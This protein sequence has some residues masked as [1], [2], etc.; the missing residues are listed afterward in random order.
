MI[1][2]PGEPQKSVLGK[3]WS[4][5]ISSLKAVF[6]PWVY[7]AD[8]SIENQRALEISRQ[9]HNKEL[10]AQRQVFRK[11]ELELSEWQRRNNLSFQAIQNE[12]HRDLQRETARLQHD[13]T[14]TEGRFNRQVQKEL[15]EA[16]RL[17]TTVEGDKNRQLQEYLAQLQRELTANEGQLNRE[18][19]L[20]LEMIRV[21]MQRWIIEQQKALQLKI[22]EIDV[23]LAWELRE[24][25]RRT[26]LNN[27]RE[28]RRLNNLPICLL[29]EDILGKES[30]SPLPLRVFISPPSIRY[31]R[32]GS[33]NR[34]GESELSRYFPLMEQA[35]ERE[36][37][38][39]CNHYV[40]H[41]RPLNPMGGAWTSKAFHGETA[42]LAMFNELH[43]EPVL[44]LE[45]AP[46]GS[47]FDLNCAFWG[48]NWK[49]PLYHTALSVD[50]HESL[51]ELAKIRTLQWQEK[52]VGKTQTQLEEQFGKEVV[53]RYQ[54]NLKMIEREQRCVAD[55]MDLKDIDRPYHIA[56]KDSERFAHFL[57]TCHCLYTG[58][59]A[60]EYFLVHVPPTVRQPPLL[61]TLLPE[62]L[63]EVPK[64]LIPDLVSIMVTFY[65]FLYEKLGEEL[66][67]WKPQLYLELA[68]S[69]IVLSDQS[70]TKVQVERAI[71]IWMQ[72][73]GIQITSNEVPEEKSLALENVPNYATM[74]SIVNAGDK[75]FFDRLENCL[76]VL[77]A[78][79]ETLPTVE[80]FL[81]SW[82]RLQKERK[83]TSPVFKRL[84]VTIP[85]LPPQ[86]GKTMSTT[87]TTIFN[88]KFLQIQD[89]YQQWS[90]LQEK[91][92][93]LLGNSASEETGSIVET[94]LKLQMAIKEFKHEIDNPRITLATTGTT[95]GGKSS[96]VN[97]LCGAEII[98]VAV[99]EMSAGT[100]VIDHHSTKRSLKI[101]PVAGLPADYSGEWSDLSDKDIRH[102]LQK[103]MD[104]YRQ[105]R[106]EN[107]EPSAPRMEIQY[108]TRLGLHPELAG[109]PEG[110]KL[111]IIDLPGLKYVADEHNRQVIREEIKPALC[112]VTYNSEETDPN[113]QQ[114]L[115]E[116]VVEQV[117]EL[118]GSPA[119]MLFVLNRI[120]VFRRDENWQEQTKN[121][122]NKVRQKIRTAVAQSLPEYQKQANEINAQ[123]LST[124]PALCAYQVLT[125]DSEELCVQ[126]LEKIDSH[127][128]AL[129][130]EELVDELPRKISKWR[131]T[132]RKQVAEA[133]WRSSYGH[134]FDETLR[135]HIQSHIPQ[136]LLPHLVKAV[137]D[138]DG[139]ALT[140]A[141]QIAHAH[142]NATKERYQAECN[143]LN[144]I[145]ADLQQLRDNSKQ[146]LLAILD[147]SEDE[148]VDLIEQLTDVA[149]QLQ[150]TYQLPKDSLVPLYDWTIQLGNTI[151]SFLSAI[152]KAIREKSTEPQSPLTDS[153]PP[154]ERQAL[155]NMLVH[156]NE[157]GYI[158]YAEEGGHFDTDN[159]SQKEELKKMNQALN[160]LAEVIAKSLRRLLE[161]TAEREAG[162]IQ[163]ALQ[164]LIEQY[165]LFISEQA[166]S[167]APDLAALTITP[168]KLSRIKQRLILNFNLTAGFPIHKK[169]KEIQVG[170]KEVWVGTERVKTG[171]EEVKVGEKR[172]W[173]T[174]WIAKKAIYET[175]DKYETRDKYKREA[176]YEKRNYE[177]ATIPSIIDVFG[178]FIGQAKASR[179]EAEFV[180]WLHEQVDEFLTGIEE[181]QEDLLKEYRRRLDQAMQQA[182]QQKEMD[183]GKWQPVAEQVVVLQN[184]L[185]KLLKVE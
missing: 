65:E 101:P 46:E 126:S 23:K 18:Q 51:Y 47:K 152:D 94:D 44:I 67:A 99:Q 142:L 121:F 56:S 166:Y 21:E 93:Q 41:N 128:R 81:Q 149:S 167:L 64:E 79:G 96:L 176:V 130:P 31:D 72:Q 54:H 146:A 43:T 86:S 13:T 124:Y 139:V 48:M 11:A 143:R 123:P 42:A 184:G 61:P 168:S 90:G 16:Q 78:K 110:F 151:E 162:R 129:M 111:R 178:G 70:W 160:E 179:T 161:R 171:T 84:P 136:L 71:Q 6:L 19:S 75:S 4:G 69:L 8:S 37:R 170:T 103:V 33:G 62:L 109:L 100:V 35:L 24:Y 58:M 134:G 80:Q 148:E 141:H 3:I 156:L 14:T 138:V 135:G 157:S 113:K 108:P 183:I 147:F 40:N 83:T 104:S 155:S 106:E 114:R 5:A 115:L 55:G 102:R 29:A 27:I 30:T 180:R 177:A 49:K 91:I 133:V 45:S 119:R 98:P 131:E 52:Q 137:T 87:L 117:R 68:E 28:Q 185:Q 20:N 164:I 132:E 116:E 153:L 169:T 12:H 88:Q 85:E 182:T 105:L 1:L 77:Q 163:D 125:S 159:S 60:D 32:S 97:L 7:T 36:L 10:E 76:T 66:I 165:A 92:K 82:S 57:T 181:Y 107:R 53:A 38:A 15:A 150:Q 26:A 127:F 2:L 172:T 34:A 89:H 158:K 73:K 112:L 174:L 22:K 154:G 120:D 50:W 95:S 9:A 63:K 74:Q 122:T 175:Q 39:F 17:L 140:N 173:Y 118:R 25:D 59:F 145:S 144:R